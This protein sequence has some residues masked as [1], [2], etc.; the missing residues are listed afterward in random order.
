MRFNPVDIQLWKTGLD[1]PG[2]ARRLKV[3]QNSSFLLSK[4]ENRFGLSTIR[5]ALSCSAQYP[6]NGSQPGPLHVSYSESTQLMLT[7]L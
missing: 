7:E 2:H 5:W 6:D 3:G 4:Y 1:A